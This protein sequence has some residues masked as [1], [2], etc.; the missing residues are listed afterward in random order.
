M[1]RVS[2]LLRVTIDDRPGSLGQLAVA[3]GG[4]GADIISLEVIDRGDGFAVDDIVVDLPIG[5]LPD[6]LITAASQAG[7]HVDSVRPYAGVLDTHR[8][9][10]LV[11]HVA[12]ARDNRL[13]TLV[14]DAPH[15]LR[16]SWA[17]IVTRA[18]SGATV[19]VCGSSG[20]PETPLASAGWLP[21]P[22][23][24]IVDPHDA[25][26]P[27]SWR[28]S[29]TRLVAAPLDGSHRALLLGRVGGPDFRPAEVARLGYLIGIIGNVGK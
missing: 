19:T 13:Q 9:L 26:V 4:V 10:E 6:T 3:L 22:Q 7:A 25:G 12:T 8:E 20:A 17:T 11:D 14:D 18:D 15:V 24:A 28:D 29:D 5:A 1:A 16:A 27:Q 2:Y 23:A 21:L